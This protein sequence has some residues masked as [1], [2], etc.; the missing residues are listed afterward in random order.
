MDAIPDSA[1]VNE[2][3]RLAQKRGFYNLKGFVNGVL[4][5]AAREMDE[6]VY[7]SRTEDPVEYLSVSYSMPQWI[8]R[9]WL[10][11]FSFEEVERIC[12]S[13]RQESPVTVRLR[14]D[15]VSR[16]E[17]IASMKEEGCVVTQHPYLDYAV[18]ISGYYYL[19]ALTAFR[20]GWIYVQDVGVKMG[21]MMLVSDMFAVY[22]FVVQ[23]AVV[24]ETV[25]SV[26]TCFLMAF[27][28]RV[29][30]ATSALVSANHYL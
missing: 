20:Q 29:T 8:L 18:R 6:I 9:K 24:L 4:R 26:T 1:V 12:E 25:Q 14:T 21:R 19:Q 11:Q 13:F 3:V 5:A 17:I 16:E 2:A 15:R 22:Y 28:F 30:F 27:L 10:D 7:P 23:L